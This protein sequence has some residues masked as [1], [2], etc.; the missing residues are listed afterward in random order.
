MNNKY[1]LLA[2]L[3]FLFAAC[4]NL[5]QQHTNKPNTM[6]TEN[7]AIHLSQTLTDY[8]WSYQTQNN[9]PNI[10]VNFDKNQR[11]N[12]ATGCNQQGGTWQLKDQ[13]LT[14]SPLHSTLMMCSPELMLQEK[15]SA[16]LFSQA[17]LKIQMSHDQAHTPQ[18]QLT[19]KNGKTYLFKGEIKP[20][21][22]YQSEGEIIFL[23]IAPEAKPCL[24]NPN[25]ECLQVKEIK[26]NDQ[27]IQSDI[28]QNWKILPESIQGYTHDP[29]MKK[30]IRVKRFKS[31]EAP[32]KYAYI[33]DMTVQQDILTP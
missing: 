28:D 25:A 29:K 3:P 11:F 14:T 26:Y 21:A 31:K 27:G 30:V 19:D 8:Y 16:D 23:A 2:V 7:K 24:T 13:A 32:L 4:Q 33:Y 10:T 5:P 22:Q 12:I 18:L 17:Q 15:R 6:L 1:L 9:L 20:E